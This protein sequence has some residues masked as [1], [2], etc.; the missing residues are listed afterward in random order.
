METCT[1]DIYVNGLLSADSTYT[2]YM[3]SESEPEEISSDVARSVLSKQID[4]YHN[5]QQSA[6]QTLGLALSS[7][8]IAVSIVV[9]GVPIFSFGTQITE[10][11]I[12]S[13]YFYIA[14]A[15][16]IM[17]LLWCFLLGML[18]SISALIQLIQLI[19]PKR[20]RPII[21][22]GGEVSKYEIIS[23]AMDDERVK[24][25]LNS[26]SETLS[27]LYRIQE[28]SYKNLTLLFC[29]V[30]YALITLLA[31]NQGNLSIIF[32]ISIMIT[33]STIAVIIGF[34]CYNV[35]K[36]N[37]RQTLGQMRNHFHDITNNI[38][39]NQSIS[40]DKYSKYIKNPSDYIREKRRQYA[41]APFPYFS[42]ALFFWS[43][44]YLGNILMVTYILIDIFLRTM[45]YVRSFVA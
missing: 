1:L 23:G 42:L 3:S 34:G 9:A 36:D 29:V 7:A 40:R 17:N 8:S 25:M 6:R 5:V 22:S 32:L 19:W 35:R 43:L 11:T 41:F 31:L 10:P 20:F 16:S 14:V 18:H 33:M 39:W 26:N 15:L 24:Q 44:L 27:K 13:Q 37:V 38:S 4:S 28:N 21:D 45:D 2:K 12:L 30:S